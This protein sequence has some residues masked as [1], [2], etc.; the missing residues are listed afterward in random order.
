MVH[1]GRAL[2]Q[3]TKMWRHVDGSTT[4]SRAQ[5]A[6]DESDVKNGQTCLIMYGSMAESVRALLRNR[7]SAQSM[8]ETVKDNMMAS[9]ASEALSLQTAEGLTRLGIDDCKD[10]GEYCARFQQYL[11]GFSMACKKRHEPTI[12]AMTVKAFLEGLRGA[13]TWDLIVPALRQR[14]RLGEPGAL[15]CLM[16]GACGFEGDQTNQKDGSADA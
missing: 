13:E 12:R 9:E 10:V 1:V 7:Q 15:E 2:P 6:R 5:D 11:N 4:K 16:E 14:V 3:S 8:W